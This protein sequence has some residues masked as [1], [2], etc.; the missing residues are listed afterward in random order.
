MAFRSDVV[1]ELRGEKRADMCFDFLKT[2]EKADVPPADILRAWTTN[3]YELLGIAKQQGPITPGMAGDMIAVPENPL[4]NIYTLR[5][6]DFVMKDGQIV[7]R[8]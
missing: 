4:K 7:R 6:V 1:V 8:P 5:K 3:A 2:W